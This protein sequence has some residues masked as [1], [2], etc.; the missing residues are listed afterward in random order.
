MFGNGEPVV[1]HRAGDGGVD[2]WGNPLPGSDADVTFVGAVFPVGT[3]E[4]TAGQDVNVRY[5]RVV[6]DGWVD[7]APTDEVTVRGQRLK[8]DGPASQYHSPFTGTEV[9]EVDLVVKS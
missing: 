8:V 4:L 1:R 9:T 6:L 3:A 5:L 7:V 2:R